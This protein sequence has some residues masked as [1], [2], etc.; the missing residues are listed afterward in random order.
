M[1]HTPDSAMEATVEGESQGRIITGLP[2]ETA[3]LGVTKAEQEYRDAPTG[4]P[5]PTATP[6]PFAETYPLRQVFPETLYWNPDALTDKEG[7]LTLD[8]PLADTI[9]TWRL[10]AL[11][12]T[13]EG[14]M[15][16]ANLDLV[17][18]QDIFAEID[19]PT[20]QTTGEPVTVTVTVYN[21]SAQT[22][23]VRLQA[24]SADWYRPLNA[25]QELS[26]EPNDLS[27][28][29]L[30]LKPER[31]GKFTLEVAVFSEE[32]VDST[33]IPVLVAPASP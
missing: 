20:P 14:H 29:T 7:R 1:A 15:G 11:A 18:F 8:I 26:I 12:T 19:A 16:S 31:A 27:T 21:Y 3:S 23:R 33:S 17:V 22:Q 25:A 13:R 2:T 30:T 28:A 24:E 4:T 9:T 10:T 5:S 32:T 6:V